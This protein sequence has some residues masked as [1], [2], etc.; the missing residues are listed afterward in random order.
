MKKNV[1]LKNSTV[2]MCENTRKRIFEL[3]G[4]NSL[5]L[6]SKVVTHLAL[7]INISQRSCLNTNRLFT[8]FVLMRVLRLFFFRR[9]FLME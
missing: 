4:Q 7:G 5:A 2:C 8:K 1:L 9:D 3:G 6:S